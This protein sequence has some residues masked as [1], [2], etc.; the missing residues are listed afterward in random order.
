MAEACRR[1]R[2]LTPMVDCLTVNVAFGL[3]KRKQRE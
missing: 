1:R 3:T 2:A